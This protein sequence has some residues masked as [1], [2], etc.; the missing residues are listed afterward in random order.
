MSSKIRH[1]SR[2]LSLLFVP[3]R[4]PALLKAADRG[5]GEYRLFSGGIKD[6][7]FVHQILRTFFIYYFTGKSCLF[8]EVSCKMK[9]IILQAASL[10]RG[11][12]AE[13]LFGFRPGTGRPR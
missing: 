6:A 8:K 10:T 9:M 3:A 11:R 12:A 7:F 5:R 2:L 13:K 4:Q 1:C